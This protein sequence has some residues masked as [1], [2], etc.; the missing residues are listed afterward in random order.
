MSLHENGTI[1]ESTELKTLR[2]QLADL[3]QALDEAIHTKD[4]ARARRAL[5]AAQVG[6]WEWETDTG[7]V[8]W[9]PE[10][11]QIYG[12]GPGTF[13]G[14]YEAFLER[15]YPPD[16]DQVERA[17]AAALATGQP[18][19][20][21]HRVTWPDGSIRWL[22]ARGRAILAAGEVTGMAG[23]VEDITDLKLTTSKLD[24][25]LSLLQEQMQ[26]RAAKLQDAME[27]F[28]RELHQRQRVESAFR[29]TERRYQWLYDN[30][31]SMYFTLSPEGI[32]ESVNDFGASQLGYRPEELVGRS[33]L[34]VF[35]A[36][37]HD[38]VLH[39]LAHCVNHL[40]I[41][42]E[43]ELQKV[44]KDGSRL[45][46]HE[47]ARA[48]KDPDGRLMILVVCED[49][50][51]HRQAT[52]LLST[53][54]RECALPIV[55]LDAEA[56]VTSWNQAATRLFGWSEEEVLGKE[57]PYVP[58]G[59]EANA[60]ALWQQGREGLIS[61]P[62]ELR[63]CRKDGTL[64]DL[65]LWPVLAHDDE[66]RTVT[67]VGLFVDQSELKRAEA[68]LRFMQTV[69]DRAADMA[70]WVA[71]DARL[72]YANDAACR[73]LGYSRGQLLTMR[74]SDIDPDYQPAS[75]PSHWE[76]LRQAGQLRFET[77]HRASSGEIYPVEIVAN[78]IVFDGQEYAFS[79]TR[80]ISDR[81]QAEA[82]LRASELTLQRFVEEAP[83][84]L[85]ILDNQRRLLS[86]NKA[87]CELTGYDE[88]DLIG[89]TYE[90]YTHPDD[91]PRNRM[92]TD[93]FYRGVRAEY[94][95]EKRY[96]RKSGDIIWVSVKATG[97]EL[98]SHPGPLL[99]AAV[100]DITERRRVAEE[101]ERFSQDLHDNILQSLY[102]VGMQLEAS[103]LSFGRA[104]RKSKAYT[105]LAI[106]HLN[107]LVVEVR[108]FI[109]LLRQETVPTLD[110]GQA[111]R[112]LA[113][114][115]SPGGETETELDIKDAVIAM[116]TAEQGEQLL[117]IAREALSNS[118][119][120]AR[121]EHRWVRLTRVGA[122]IR[123]Q[124]CDDG[125]GFDPKRK[126]KPGH[127]L[128]NMAARAKRIHARF[129]LKTRPGQGVSITVDLPM[130][131]L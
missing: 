6:T 34:A 26:E 116:I 28:E 107:R 49:V 78:H 29:E 60:D 55:S 52:H 72:L 88:Q 10:V 83:I 30:N 128:A 113:A 101:R 105:V 68:K 46:V 91:L 110:F 118:M 82:A 131:G 102:A 85:V 75:W 56:R 79:F 14:T 67:A 120:H 96:V 126:R 76:E 61:G 38:A 39:Q 117:N 98:P 73:R 16:R 53:L 43:W 40:S 33:V 58:P 1:D 19:Y 92:L 22:A 24:Q 109:A 57:L 9:S 124:I 59:E 108:Q 94:T 106:E 17:V 90:L 99:L 64:L 27:A 129:S 77:R 121:A 2:R 65:L 50:T 123:M 84:G 119:R 48:V 41:T 112:Q 11:E 86:A 114:S 125:I 87:F 70:L 31:P 12:L 51:E 23:T 25:R 81:K 80:D 36:S 4:D 104:P 45:W 21:E 130:E 62:I 35:E 100:Q 66:G 47:R 97:I 44:R 20:I 93:D 69:V 5:R 37:N 115:F 42:H 89:R 18:Y 3:Q 103:K 63:R 8:V 71:P 13:G 111:L 127:G 95:I 32:V 74:V 7:R 122:A 15:V 54:V